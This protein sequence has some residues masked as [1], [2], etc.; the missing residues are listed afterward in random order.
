[1]LY[2]LIPNMPEHQLIPL[3]DAYARA[4]STASEFSGLRAAAK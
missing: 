1:M 2:D 4:V 3:M